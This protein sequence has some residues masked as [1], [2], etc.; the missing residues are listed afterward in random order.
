[1]FKYVDILVVCYKFMNAGELK[2]ILKKTEHIP[3]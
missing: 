3:V 1:M 2:L